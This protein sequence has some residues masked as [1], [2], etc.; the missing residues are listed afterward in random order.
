[1]KRIIRCLLAA[2]L[3]FLMGAQ[4]PVQAFAQTATDGKYI[5]EIKLGIGKNSADAEA[6]LNGYEILKD[7]NGNY[8][9]LN[10][11]AG[12]TN[13][14]GKGNRVVYLGYIRTTSENDAIDGR[15]H[16]GADPSLC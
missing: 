3:A 13:F 6:A 1:M 12:T 8:V 11:N 16:S 9:D 4:L 7:A 10:R 5:S 2:A 14:G 15:F